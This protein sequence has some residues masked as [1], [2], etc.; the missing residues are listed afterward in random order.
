ML[1]DYLN[2]RVLMFL[3]VPVLML[4]RVAAAQPEPNA[5]I[6]RLAARIEVQKNTNVSVDEQVEIVLPTSE[7]SVV[8]SWGR[9]NYLR[10]FKWQIIRQ[11]GS[12][13]VDGSIRNV[14][15]VDNDDQTRVTILEAG[16][17]APG[18]HL[19]HIAYTSSGKFTA[20]GDDYAPGGHNYH[21]H[22]GV[23]IFGAL[24]VRSS[25]VQD[26]SVRA[27]R[28]E[29]VLPPEVEL[30]D[31]VVRPAT[32]W[33][34]TE[35]I[36][37]CKIASSPAEHSIT[38]ETTREGAPVIDMYFPS[39]SLTPDRAESRR[40]EDQTHPN[41]RAL[42]QWGVSVSFYVVIAA[43]LLGYTNR[44]SSWHGY[45]RKALWGLALCAGTVAVAVATARL[46][47]LYI[48]SPGLLVGFYGSMIIFPGGHGPTEQFLIL[49]IAITVQVIFYY[50]LGRVVLLLLRPTVHWH[51][52]K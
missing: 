32:R 17:Y 44:V 39:S 46:D 21:L 20:D 11:L 42:R 31:V 5:S 19:I 37:D 43:A 25:R 47:L 3:T 51:Y 26:I 23:G 50:G 18:T 41:L 52:N 33:T 14:R 4:A 6:A 10:S 38:I 34:A 8:V 22:M 45:D 40:L 1:L 28:V 2:S 9:F 48:G 15:S 35:S 12:I 30:S 29:L 13:S 7:S 16:T 24:P 49:P 36:C 27:A